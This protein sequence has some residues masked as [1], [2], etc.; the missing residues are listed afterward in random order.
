MAN[1][2][3]NTV[4]FVTINSIGGVGKTKQRKIIISANVKFDIIELDSD[5]ISPDII[6]KIFTNGY[7]EDTTYIERR[8]DD[9]GSIAIGAP[10]V[11]Q[12]NNE[13]IPAKQRQPLKKI[14]KTQ[15][16]NTPVASLEDVTRRAAAVM[17]AAKNPTM[18]F[19]ADESDVADEAFDPD[20][21][22]A[23]V[24]EGD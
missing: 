4:T 16:L 22:Q 13:S 18:S 19:S 21:T 6:T 20:V 10:S 23:P 3:N 17:R 15:P 24:D 7:H 8:T 11:A 1:T 9:K 14:P 12:L 5:Q 2:Q